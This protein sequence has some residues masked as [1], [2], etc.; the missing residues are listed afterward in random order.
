MQTL[1]IN[2]VLEL[3][4]MQTLS[5]QHSDG[6]ISYKLSQLHVLKLY[7][8]FIYLATHSE[9]LPFHHQL[10]LTFITDDLVKIIGKPGKV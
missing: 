3:L 4:A 10:F 7:K 5:N 1:V 9:S 2:T 8:L 6:I